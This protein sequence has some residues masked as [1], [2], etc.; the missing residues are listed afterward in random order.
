ME[1]RHSWLWETLNRSSVV[2]KQEEGWSWV[3]VGCKQMHH[4]QVHL[5]AHTP[6][7][8]QALLRM[9]V[10]GFVEAEV[11]R[12]LSTGAGAWGLVGNAALPTTDTARSILPLCRGEGILRWT[13]LAQGSTED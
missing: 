5:Q 1:E 13:G 12:A 6:K 11:G 2:P 3:Q 4:G 8:G 10:V 9:A 7:A